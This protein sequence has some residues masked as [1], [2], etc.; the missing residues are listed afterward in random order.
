MKLIVAVNLVRSAACWD[1]KAC[2]RR[3]CSRGVSSVMLALLTLLTLWRT[4]EAG[5]TRKK[6][7]PLEQENAVKARPDRA[8]ADLAFMNA[9]R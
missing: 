6:P 5:R 4:R 8:E 1:A 2:T 3:T 7:A 9:V